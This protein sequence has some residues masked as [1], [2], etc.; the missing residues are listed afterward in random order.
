MFAMVMPGQGAQRKGM[1]TPWL[2][3]AGS[4]LIDEYSQAADLDLRYYGTVAENDEITD[5]AIAQPLIVATSLLVFDRLRSELTLPDRLIF[6]GHSVGELAAAAAAGAMS[7]HDAVRL[8][9]LRGLAMRSACDHEPTGMAAVVGGGLCEVTRAVEELG[10]FVANVN[11]PGQVVAAGRLEDLDQLRASPPPDTQIKLL[12]VAGAFHSPYMA[13]AEQEFGAALEN[14]AVV[15]S[16]YPLLSNADGTLVTGPLDLKHRL[17]RQLT[18]QVRWDL[19]VRS[20]R[21]YRA[22]IRVELGKGA[23]SGLTRRESPAPQAIQ[24]SAPETLVLVREALT[25]REGAASPPR[26]VS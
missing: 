11:G 19:C 5:T 17:V 9:R 20:L 1:I 18:R 24:A 16:R 23:L 13:S 14:T 15:M 3:D 4:A 7:P 6:A 21:Q 10:L 25:R 2:D 8:A 26:L 22:D 12:Q